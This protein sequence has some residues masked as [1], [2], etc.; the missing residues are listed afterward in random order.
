MARS[1]RSRDVGGLHL[2]STFL[3]SFAPTARWSQERQ[4]ASLDRICEDGV[5]TVQVEPKGNEL[6]VRASGELDIA[7]AKRLEDAL[8]QAINSDA[9]AV[10]L[11]LGGLSFIDSTGLRVLLLA[12]KLSATNRTP[13]RMVGAREPIREVIDV[14]GLEHSLPLTA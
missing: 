11:D 9:S 3:S 5:L 8:E 12:A 1:D 2:V 10:V 4:L 7:S 13:L 6:V 14:S